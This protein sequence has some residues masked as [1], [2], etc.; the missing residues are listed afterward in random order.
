MNQNGFH[1]LLKS[2]FR[3][4]FNRATEVEIPKI[5]LEKSS[6]DKNLISAFQRKAKNQFQHL[7]SH[8]AEY[9]NDDSNSMSVR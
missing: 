6:L 9:A 3:S 1:P 8:I 5:V 4:S 7:N 2:P